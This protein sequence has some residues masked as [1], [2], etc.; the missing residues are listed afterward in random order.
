MAGFIE[1][2]PQNSAAV[3]LEGT[4]G[5]IWRHSEGCIKAKQLR[6]EHVVIRS[7]T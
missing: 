3:I 7:K 1:F 5:D 6:V 2:D 4:S